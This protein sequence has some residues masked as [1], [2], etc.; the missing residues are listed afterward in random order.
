[1]GKLKILYH[2]K[3]LNSLYKLFRLQK[4]YMNA[5]IHHQGMVKG[6]QD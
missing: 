3:I 6:I 1:M 4:I 5:F 2:G